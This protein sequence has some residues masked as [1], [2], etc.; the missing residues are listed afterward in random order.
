M[1]IEPILH[2]KT[3]RELTT[4]ELYELL[5]G[6]ADGYFIFEIFHILHFY[7]FSVSR[8]IWSFRIL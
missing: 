1:T 3:F 7:F 2:K 8:L 6:K 4:D 5:T